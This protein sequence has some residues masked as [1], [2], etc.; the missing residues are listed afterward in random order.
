MRKLTIAAVL[1]VL[2]AVPAVCQ[3][4]SWDNLQRLKA[5]NK[6]KVTQTNLKVVEGKF[7]RFTDVNLTLK[8][9]KEEV[10]VPRD[11][12][13]RV[14]RREHERNIV[15]G[16]AAGVGLGAALAACCVEREEGY[17]AAMLGTVVGLG[18]VGAGVGA[19]FPRDMTIY[20]S[21][22]AVRKN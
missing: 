2:L 9:G 3:E 20:R 17:H 8:V 16:L 10:P 15:L 14:T 19:A 21:E 4:N 5:G 7:V 12:V 18:S 6:I 11:D 1:V 13:Y 22:K